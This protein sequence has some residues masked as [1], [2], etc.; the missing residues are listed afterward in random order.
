MVFPWWCCG[1]DYCQE[2]ATAANSIIIPAIGDDG[3]AKA[4]EIT[5]WKSV[6]AAGQ[7]VHAI[8]FQQSFCYFVFLDTCVTRNLAE[9]DLG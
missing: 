2:R 8:L 3:F 5:A 9:C 1:L 7:V 4:N 6:M